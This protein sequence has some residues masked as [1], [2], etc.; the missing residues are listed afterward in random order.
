M[1][2]LKQTKR[3]KHLPDPDGFVRDYLAQTIQHPNLD[4]R[5]YK[6]VRIDLRHYLGEQNI[7]FYSIYAEENNGCANIAMRFLCRLAD[8]FR[9]ELWGHV[10]GFGHRRLDEE[11]LLRWYEL[12]GF[13][14]DKH[15]DVEGA[16]RR[17]HVLRITRQPA[18]VV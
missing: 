15:E 10:S 7:H 12:Y 5:L 17:Y 4:M 18:T 11:R 6:G 1:P 3:S 9:V 14:Q 2:S 8:Q 13:T 16:F